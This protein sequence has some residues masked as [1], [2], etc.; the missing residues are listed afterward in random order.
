MVN[1]L[2]IVVT[3]CMG[4]SPTELEEWESDP[5]EYFVRNE[6]V[7]VDG[8]ERAAAEDLYL[9]LIEV[10]GDELAPIMGSA[11]ATCESVAVSLSARRRQ[12]SQQKIIHLD[13]IYLAVGL[14]PSKLKASVNIETWFLGVPASILRAA[15]ERTANRPGGCLRIIERR[16][17]WLVSTLAHEFP[18][19][20]H[21]SS[22]SV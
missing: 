18:A 7:S 1:L 21:A 3:E 5:E 19:T 16:V 11:L 8:N 14:F 12:C 17:L 10:W 6:S 2:R 20:L 9:A 15:S 13:G 22:T 4:I